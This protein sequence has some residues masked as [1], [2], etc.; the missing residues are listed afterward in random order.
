MVSFTIF[1]KLLRSIPR[2]TSHLLIH[3]SGA[4]LWTS[5]KPGIIWMTTLS[6]PVIL[7]PSF[8]SGRKTPPTV[9]TKNVLLSRLH[10]WKKKKKR[11]TP[12]NGSARPKAS[13]NY[14]C[15]FELT[16]WNL[17]IVRQFQNKRVAI[18][19]DEEHDSHWVPCSSLHVSLFS[20]LPLAQWVAIACLTK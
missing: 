5:T 9:R 3:I 10:C 4:Q 13:F 15:V 18:I 6:N 14:P 8:C 16:F 7:C 1:L 12:V 19:H 11:H 20:L 17:G 2:H